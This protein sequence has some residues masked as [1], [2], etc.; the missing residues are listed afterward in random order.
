[1]HRPKRILITNSMPVVRAGLISYLT[2]NQDLVECREAGSLEQALWQIRASKPDIVLIEV[3]E[4]NDIEI[5]KTLQE[6]HPEII[7]IATPSQLNGQQ[8]KRLVEN[9]VTG[10][11]ILGAEKE[12]FLHAI[13]TVGTRTT[14]FCR[15]AAR[16][17]LDAL[18]HATQH[19]ASHDNISLTPRE[20]EVLA[21]I[22]E[23]LTNHEIAN[24]LGISPRTVEVH[25]RNLM[26]KTGSNQI[27]GLVMYAVRNGLLPD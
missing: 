12:E 24:R 2:E 13:R 26:E 11:V 10:I 1:M 21:L 20:L 8:I 3:G 25:K 22:L 9:G 27:A 16:A 18:V 23:D 17:A 15:Q 6:A 14:Y 19:P 4:K 7:I 5:V